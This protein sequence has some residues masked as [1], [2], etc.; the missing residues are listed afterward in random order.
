MFKL[1]D[2]ILKNICAKFLK[3]FDTFNFLIW[4]ALQ[5]AASQLANFFKLSMNNI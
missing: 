3:N 1:F 2:N 5:R 4:K